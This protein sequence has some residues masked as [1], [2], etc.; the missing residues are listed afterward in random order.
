[1]STN[2]SLIAINHVAADRADEFEQW[3]RA[4]VLPAVREHRP[5]QMDRWQMLR[6]PEQD[7]TVVYVFLFH[8]GGPAEW[9][10]LPL[11]EQTHGPETAQRLM[12]ELSGLLTEDQYGW[13][14]APVDL[15]G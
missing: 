7:D 9:E 8:G 13:E 15:A 4:N 11:L 12:G 10:L 14:L 5:D 2:P 6:A 1:M 3:L